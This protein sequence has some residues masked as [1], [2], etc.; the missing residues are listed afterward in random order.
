MRLYDRPMNEEKPKTIQTYTHWGTYHIEVD[1]GDICAVHPFDADPDPSDIGAA[2]AD[3][4]DPELRVTAPMVRKSWL[5]NGPP[6]GR[7]E[8][9]GGRGRGAFVEV[10]WEKANELVAGELSRV[11]RT[12]GPQAIFGGSYGWASAGVFHRASG[13]L[14]RFLGLAGGFTR[15]VNTY[16]VAAAETLI[17]HILGRPFFLLSNE[18]TAWPV[19][20]EHTDLMVAFGGIPMKN[21]QVNSGGLGAHRCRDWLEKLRAGGVNLVNVSPVEDDIDPQF[22]AKWLAIAPNTDTAMLLALAHS[23]VAEGMHDQAF[24]AK[25]CVGFEPFLLYLM[26]AD[27]GVAKDADWAAEITGISGQDIRNLARKM[28]GGRTMISLAWSLQRADHGEQPYWAAIALAAMLGQI[29][30]PGG[31]IGFGY[32]AQAAY[33]NPVTALGGLALPRSANRVADFIPVA[34]ITDLLE[35]PGGTFDY[36]GK[37]HT[38]PETKLI[39]WCGG[40]PFHH[41]QDLNRLA[42]AWQRPETVIVNEPWWTPTARHADIVLPAAT[43]LERN[44]IGKAANDPFIVASKKVLEPL[45]WARTDYQIF[46]GVAE[47]MGFGDEF[48]EGRNEDAWLR[49]LW[50][51]FAQGSARGKV[52]L[53]QFDDFW[54]AGH[55]ELAADDDARVLFEGFRSDPD[56]AGLN[57]PSGKI[58]IFSQTIADFGYEDCPGHPVW[59]EPAEWLGTEGVGSKYLHLIS[60]QPSTKLHSQYDFGRVSRAAKIQGREPVSIHPDDAARRGIIDGDLVRL[61]NDRG[62]CLAGAKVTNTVRPGVVVLATGAWWDPETPGGL[63]R[64]GNA[65]VLTLD[66][67]TSKLSQAPI[68]QTAL[69]ELE[70]I[71]GEMAPVQIFSGP[72]IEPGS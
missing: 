44:D 17:P 59:I 63:D 23:L 45:G 39:Y 46:S 47:K 26:G 48:S 7:V 51:L 22:D 4:A 49:H 43:S 28:A 54:N 9:D 37:R 61:F 20:A 13:Q 27:D 31:G 33:G 71:D 3:A 62:Q 41:H 58:E 69:I 12:H 68:S 16:S 2:L 15:S 50:D 11:N 8:P 21:T 36:N 19:I 57:T 42:R 55:F 6:T 38:Y 64:H 52:E 53:P 14:H 34:R 25:Y 29:G 18:L 67:G 35:N 24:L 1:E 5:E 56:G 72:E 40:N 65:N 66:K 60:N 70:K 30:L 10:S 32:G